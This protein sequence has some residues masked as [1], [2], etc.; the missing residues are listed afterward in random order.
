MHPTAP[1]TGCSGDV[2]LLPDLTDFIHSHC[3]H[4]PLTANAPEPA[5]NGYLLTVACSCGVVFERWVTREEA[6]LDMLRAASLN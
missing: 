1:R 5:W 4:C 6:E 2:T 3:P